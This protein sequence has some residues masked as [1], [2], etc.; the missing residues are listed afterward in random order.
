MALW[1]WGMFELLKARL[2]DYQEGGWP[3]RYA[4]TGTEAAVLIPV[5]GNRDNPQLI[6]TKRAEHLSTHSGEVA[7]PGGK[8]DDT[9]SSLEAT[10]LRESEEE[11][12]LDPRC[13]GIV[14]PLRPLVTRLGV[15]VTPFIGVVPEQVSLTPNPDELDSIFKV[16]IEF[17]LQD[18]RHRT[19]SITLDDLNVTLH[20]PCYEYDGFIIWGVTAMIIVEF[21]NAAFDASIDLLQPPG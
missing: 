2:S 3:L 1:F 11:I 20:I 7:F 17:L 19:D 9:D 18:K 5:T 21:L 8:R 15:K 12:G 13:V 16:P 4:T 14:R 10:A 6:L